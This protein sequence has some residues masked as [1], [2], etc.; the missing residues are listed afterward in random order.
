MTSHEGELESVAHRGVWRDLKGR[1][2]TRLPVPADDFRYPRDDSLAALEESLE[3]AADEPAIVELMRH[4]VDRRLGA[5][6]GRRRRQPPNSKQNQSRVAR[7][8]GAAVESRIGRPT[9][10]AEVRVYVQTLIAQRTR[11]LLAERG[12]SLAQV[13][14]A[15]AHSLLAHER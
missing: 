15:C 10:G 2:V 7:E 13:F 9:I 1:I 8:S 6:K 5:S 14:D 11:E 4:D 3:F 12:V